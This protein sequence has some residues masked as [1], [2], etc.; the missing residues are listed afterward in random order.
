MIN[1]ITENGENTLNELTIISKEEDY[2]I[3]QLDSMEKNLDKFLNIAPK[4]NNLPDNT[5]AFDDKI[6]NKSIELDNNLKEINKEIN[7]IQ[8]NFKMQAEYHKQK[9]ESLKAFQD[10]KSN[11]SI[12]V[13]SYNK[14]LPFYIKFLNLN[15]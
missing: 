12:D 2:I 4:N 5:H 14:D 6:Y 1:K 11:I 15:N 9:A 13:R 3:D 10:S 7:L 8:N